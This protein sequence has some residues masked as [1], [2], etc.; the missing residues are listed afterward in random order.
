MGTWQTF[1]TNAD[2]TAIVDE[3]MAAG[4]N[5]F[6]SSSMYG[7]AE[8]TLTRAIDGHRPQAII[9]TKIWSGDASEGWAQAE[10]ALR[11]F[12]RVEIDQVHRQRKRR[13]G[14]RKTR[15]PGIRP[16]SIEISERG[17][18]ASCSEIDR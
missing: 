8:H 7:R 10:H 9:S 13:V 12:G 16:G 15:P 14:R 5:L 11:R 4:I 1:D 2:R 18:R 17:W 3:A 6:D